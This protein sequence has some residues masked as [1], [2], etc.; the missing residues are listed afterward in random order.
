MDNLPMAERYYQVIIVP[1]PIKGKGRPRASCF[2]GRI[3]M[4]TPKETVNAEA[5]IKQCCIQQ[6]GN[7]VLEG[8]LIVKI[9]SFLEI[10]N[11]WSNKKKQAAKMGQIKPTGKPDIDNI[12]KLVADS[13]NKIAWK[14]DSQIVEMILQKSY[15]DNNDIK[16]VITIESA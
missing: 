5:H 11:S 13:L 3:S 1:W 8:A 9:K 16:T 12:A 4:H 7:P 2:G 14:D 15:S 6:I 10:P